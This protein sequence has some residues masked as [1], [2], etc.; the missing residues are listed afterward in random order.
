MNT[1]AA[2]CPSQAQS[3]GRGRTQA[4]PPRSQPPALQLRLLCYVAVVSGFLES[5]DYPQKCQ[6]L[7]DRQILN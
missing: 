2:R 5:P 4:G 3:D 1:A 7:K 6:T